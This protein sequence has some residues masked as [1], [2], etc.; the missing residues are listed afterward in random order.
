MYFLDIEVGEIKPCS[1]GPTQIAVNSM[2]LGAPEKEGS[3]VPT[4][5]AMGGN[6]TD[7]MGVYRST[8]GG[9]TWKRINDDTQKWGN[10]NSVIKGD[11]KT[12]GRCY[13]STNGRGIIMGNVKE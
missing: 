9:K 11:P 7:G 12:F 2:G 1:D 8:D 3:T 4:I 10:V 6:E 5:F 13:I